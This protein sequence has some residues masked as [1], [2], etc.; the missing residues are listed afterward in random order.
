MRCA[1]RKGRHMQKKSPGQGRTFR[2]TDGFLG[3]FR[4]EKTEL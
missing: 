4:L 1:K 3:M 2:R